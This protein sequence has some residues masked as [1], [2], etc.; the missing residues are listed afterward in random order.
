MA[1]GSSSKVKLEAVT[2]GQLQVYG[3]RLQSLWLDGCFYTTDVVV[4][5]DNVLETMALICCIARVKSPYVV[6]RLKGET[7]G[8]AG[9]RHEEPLVPAWAD[10]WQGRR[11]RQL[12]GSNMAEF[13][14]DRG[15]GVKA[16]VLQPGGWLCDREVATMRWLA[17][18]LRGLA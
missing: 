17:M 16:L 7:G 15:R 18:S 6:A 10:R 1:R 14:N 9:D 3:S 8:V 5:Q 4:A 11:E 12:G 2:S 13:F